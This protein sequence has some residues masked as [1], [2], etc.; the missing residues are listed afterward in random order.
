MAGIRDILIHQYDNVDIDIVWKTATQFI[1]TLK[2]QI[3][4]IL[5]II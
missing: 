5:K 3:I 4:E 1:P 2:K